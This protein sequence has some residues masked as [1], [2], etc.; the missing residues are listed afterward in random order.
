M[1]KYDDQV[2]STSQALEWFK[3]EC[4]TPRCVF[5]EYLRREAERV[6]AEEL[7]PQT[8]SRGQFLRELDSPGS[9]FYRRF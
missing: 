6:K 1:G 8:I 2:D 5:L 3:Q 9:F 7:R 4:I